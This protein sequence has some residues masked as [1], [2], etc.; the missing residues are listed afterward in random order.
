MKPEEFEKQIARILAAISLKDAQVK[1]NDRF[2]DPDNPSQLRQVDISIRRGESLTL[3]ECRLHNRP[4]DVK[5]I[6][7]LYGR[8][9]SLNADAVIGVSSSGFTKGAYEKARRLGVF[10]RCLTELS[11]AEIAEWGRRTRCRISFV[12][13]SR[14]QLSIVAS[15][16]V[17]IPTLPSSD[18][19]RTD[20]GER[21]PIFDMLKECA[22]ALCKENAPE[23]PFSM[24]FHLKKIVLGMQPV[25]EAILS[26]HW[27]WL[28]RDVL[29]PTVLAFED[30]SD[31]PI[32][33][34]PMVEKNA[35]SRTEIHHTPTGV[36]P[37][38][39]ISLT[40]LDECCFLRR[41]E[42][43]YAESMLMKG[44]AIIGLGE[45]RNDLCRFTVGVIRRSSPKYIS[46]MQSPR[47]Q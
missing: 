27:C 13:F 36:F 46:L 42:M 45:P 8:R 41:V 6:E 38:V 47:A 20:Q 32:L 1:W 43:V 2:P 34:S 4:Q 31:L 12:K 19:L 10:L 3:V 30:K 25:N 16:V 26:A 40:P 15:D 21:F 33:P 22:N 14:V 9:A 23:G 24:Q 28:H 7:E 35:Y 37:V 5:W 17:V 44:I 39:D 11:D 18:V 29:L